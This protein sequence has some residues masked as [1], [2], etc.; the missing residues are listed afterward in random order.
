L[1]FVLSTILL[2][3]TSSNVLKDQDNPTTLWAWCVYDWANSVYAL[4][5]SSA[6]FPIYYESVMKN[7]AIYSV[8][9]DGHAVYYVNFFGRTI[10]SSSLYAYAISF[11]ILMV[12]CM[13]PLLSGIADFGGLRKAMMKF[14][15]YLGSIA[16]M[17]LFFFNKDT[18][19]W[20]ILCCILASIGY[21]GSLVFYNAYL[22]EITVASKFDRLSARGFSMGYWGG[23]IQLLSSIVLIENY[24]FFGFQEQGTPTRISFL[25]VGV[26]WLGFAQIPFY[27]LPRN[28]PK[29]SENY[30]QL[31]LKG[32]LELKIVW[33]SLKEHIQLKRF[34]GAFFFYTMGLQTVMLLAVLFGT[35]VIGVPGDHLIII[36][37]LI[38][39][40]AVV[41]AYYSARLSGRYGNKLVLIYQV[42][43]WAAIC[44]IA[45]F[46]QTELHFFIIACFIGLVMGG[47][48]ALSRSSYSKL[49]PSNS[50]DTTS[51]FS[52]YD[53][54]E[55][56]ATVLGTVSFGLI[57]QLTQNM[58]HA[59]I[60]LALYF[61]VGLVILFSVHFKKN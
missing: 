52:F 33:M 42:S 31:I 59:I 30:T 47:I 57:E 41:G 36:V 40:L 35:E 18:L 50:S 2:L 17:G 58:R 28:K 11:S 53:A 25:L 8:K 48:Q 16:C 3:K 22:P 15:V 44:I 6:I 37:M 29:R 23:I 39:I 54:T 14:F 55:K 19:E 24:Q 12:A 5:I 61:M 43:T 13:I 45:Y 7:A 46:I 21:S 26:W 20:G 1:P 32:Y 51:Y 38:Q 10:A 9:V 4:C 60:F 49:V 56:M 34:L 27:Y